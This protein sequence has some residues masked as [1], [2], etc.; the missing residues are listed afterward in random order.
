MSSHEVNPDDARQA[1]IERSRYLLFVKEYVAQ[2]CEVVRAQLYYLFYL[3]SIDSKSMNIKY[4]VRQTLNHVV[5]TFM[6][7]ENLD[8]KVDRD[9][10]LNAA[11]NVFFEMSDIEMEKNLDIVQQKKV[12]RDLMVVLYQTKKE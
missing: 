1:I 8:F 12:V 2:L 4:R 3:H 11:K 10:L 7:M 9:V 5:E 6:N